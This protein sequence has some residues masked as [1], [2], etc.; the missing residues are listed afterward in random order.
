MEF[1]EIFLTL[2]DCFS[3]FCFACY[4]FNFRIFQ[5]WI[6]IL[7]MVTFSYFWWPQKSIQ[8]CPPGFLL[9]NATNFGQTIW[10]WSSEQHICN[11]FS[12]LEYYR[13]LWH[14]NSIE[15][16]SWTTIVPWQ[17]FKNILQNQSLWNCC[18]FFLRTKFRLAKLYVLFIIF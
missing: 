16:R 8:K 17:S 1:G 7:Y 3:S 12:M 18:L 6:L 15:K 4:K 11:V 9:W 10:M 13:L 14:K 2:K 5:V